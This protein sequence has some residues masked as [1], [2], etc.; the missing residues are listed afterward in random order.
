LR[1]ICTPNLEGERLGE[2][3]TCR[4]MARI[5]AAR[6]DFSAS[7]RWLRR[8][9]TSAKLR[10]SPREAALNQ[11]VRGEILSRQGHA[12]AA[13]RTMAEAA[14]QL[15]ALGMHWHAAASNPRARPTVSLSRS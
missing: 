3:M 13:S 12:E 14:A 8:A 6:D 9:E 5:A 11:S 10:G 4:A 1:P 7:Q 15:R 2:A